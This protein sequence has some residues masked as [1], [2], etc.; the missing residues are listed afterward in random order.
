M[1]QVRDAARQLQIYSTIDISETPSARRPQLYALM[2]TWQYILSDVSD[3]CK[4]MRL[5]LSSHS[6]SD[7]ERGNLNL[8]ITTNHRA[9]NTASRSASE[10]IAPAKTL[11]ID[12]RAEALTSR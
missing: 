1:R 7:V 5:S 11:A 3:A 4:R 12:H 9:A 8:A 6:G 10:G 2:P